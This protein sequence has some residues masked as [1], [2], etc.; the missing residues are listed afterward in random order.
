MPDFT[1]AL[2][3]QAQIVINQD[4]SSPNAGLSFLTLDYLQGAATIDAMGV[5]TPVRP[6]LVVI[7]VMDPVNGEILDLLGIVRTEARFAYDRGL[8]LGSR[9]LSFLT[10]RVSDGLN[11]GS[12]VFWGA[13]AILDSP[14]AVPL[15]PMTLTGVTGM[16]STIDPT[17]VV[18]TATFTGSVSDSVILE[19]LDSA[20]GVVGINESRPPSNPAIWN[21]TVAGRAEQAYTVSAALATTGATV[22]SPP[23]TVIPPVGN[24]VIVD[25]GNCTVTVTWDTFKTGLMNYGITLTDS[26]GHAYALANIS[27]SGLS[28]SYIMDAGNI[29]TSSI[30][31]TVVDYATSAQAV[32]PFI[33]YVLAPS[34]TNVQ[35]YELPDGFVT[36]TWQAAGL[37]G[38]LAVRLDGPA[39]TDF[40]TASGSSITFKPFDFGTTTPIPSGSYAALVSGQREIDGG[41]LSAYSGSFNYTAG[42]YSISAS[43]NGHGI[44]N[45]VVSTDVAQSY[46]ITI[47]DSAGVVRATQVANLLA[48]ANQL[49]SVDVLDPGAT[50][51]NY[52]ATITDTAGDSTTSAPFPFTPMIPM[53]GYGTS[54][55]GTTS[56]GSDMATGQ[57]TN[58]QDAIIASANVAQAPM[59]FD[60]NLGTAWATAIPVGAFI[61][62]TF[63]A[64]KAIALV[65]L[66]SGGGNQ[67]RVEGTDDG[68]TWYTY[69]APVT[70][71]ETGTTSI[72]IAVPFA[73][74]GIR[75]FLVSAVGMSWV[76]SELRLRLA[77][78]T[79]V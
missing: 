64:A 42:N 66:N 58:L 44:A 33:S 24:V 73:T 39:I 27:S 38:A 75:A 59:A 30:N 8:S 12:A 50:A 29:P 65:E 74:A 31:A 26:S 51:G 14:G 78:G 5:I 53:L 34:L 23:F 63:S 72:P 9:K 70:E 54:G 77:D 52:T 41:L 4:S 15:N 2:G 21:F 61:G 16:Q 36:V 35:A 6:G 7:R 47:N 67:V 68:I 79:I 1:L 40:Q 28:H 10:S 19:L 57:V 76:V 37:Q 49:V 3:D 56:Y 48:G 71:N 22:V 62:K 18:V 43:D 13:V 25:N 46:T 32:S 69:Q 20:G 45:V 55:Y 60:S 11:L 17:L